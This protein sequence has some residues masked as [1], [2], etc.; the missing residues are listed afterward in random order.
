MVYCCEYV[1]ICS[2]SWL[3]YNI[4]NWYHV[5]W[6][7]TYVDPKQLQV[8]VMQK[9]GGYYK[10][11]LAEDKIFYSYENVVQKLSPPMVVGNLDSFPFMT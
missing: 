8:N 2:Q 7:V 1:H 10:W 9:S 5:S 3:K 4:S 6:E 11:P